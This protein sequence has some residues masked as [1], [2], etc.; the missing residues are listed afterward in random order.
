MLSEIV[1]GLKDAITG[2]HE[3][4]SE[5]VS[6]LA[7]RAVSNN[8]GEQP[9]EDDFRKITG[10]LSLR[11]MQIYKLALSH[12]REQ[13]HQPLHKH[14]QAQLFLK[15]LGLKPVT[16][17]ILSKVLSWIVKTVL[18]SCGFMA[19]GALVEHVTGTEP[20]SSSSSSSSV[21]PSPAPSAQQLFKPDPSYVDEK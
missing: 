20:A 7:S 9:T 15:F 2:G 13:L 3:I 6:S 11:E 21:A 17:S 10:A 1:D 16:A 12:A 19:A 14:A 5:Q 8:Y 18:I 4:S